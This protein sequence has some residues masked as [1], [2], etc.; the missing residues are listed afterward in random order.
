MPEFCLRIP[1]IP[2]EGCWLG[3]FVS[4]LL[5]KFLTSVQEDFVQKPGPPFVSRR[6]KEPSEKHSIDATAQMAQSSLARGP[7]TLASCSC[8]T[9]EPLG[10]MMAEPTRILGTL[11]SSQNPSG[12]LEGGG[13][14]RVILKKRADN[15]VP[16]LTRLLSALLLKV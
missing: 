13:A 7:K 4:P 5:Q 14:G 15:M 2:F 1:S 10:P 12:L 6:S 16:F 3:G 8:F 11:E 9:L